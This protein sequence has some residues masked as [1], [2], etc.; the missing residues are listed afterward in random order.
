MIPIV[1]CGGAGARLWP[2]SE[3]KPFYNFFD[4]RSLLEISLER[5]KDFEPLLII[6]VEKLKPAV[7]EVLKGKKYK[8]EIIYEP[9]S[10]NTAVSVALVCHLLRKRQKE[11]DIV[12]IFPSDHFVGKELEFQKLISVGIQVAKEER[13]VV[14]FGVLPHSPCSDYGHIKVGDTYREFNGCSVKQAFGFVEKPDFSK[15]LSLTKEGYLWN[16]GIFLSPV[17]LLIQYFEEYLPDLW[18]QILCVE[19]DTIRSVYQN[20]KP[21]SFDKGIMEKISQYLCLP[22]DIEWSDLGSWDRM[23]DLNRRS[24]EKLNNKAHVISKDSNGNFVL[25]FVGKDIGLIGVKDILV[26]NGKEGL[27]IANKGTGESVKYISEKFKQQNV[28]QKKKWVE[29]PWGAYRVIMEEG[30]FKYKELKVKPGHQLSYQSHRKRREHW[31]VI[32]GLAEVTIE[33]NTSQLKANE[34]IFI[35]QGVKHRLKNP[36]EEE[37]LL[38]EIQMGNYLEEDDIIRYADDYGRS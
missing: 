28:K 15:S 33:G 8:T 30:F 37:L 6:S 7:E 24:P 3:K 27:L 1:L 23:A 18:R 29:K 19:K 2:V 14:T 36:I 12:G 31:L 17:D 4:D 32:S 34:H 16:S 22:F 13:K 5:L 9:E 21:V 10:R 20:I 25:S 11:K 35:A 38:L 26:V